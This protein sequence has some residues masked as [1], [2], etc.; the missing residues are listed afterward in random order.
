MD[1][2]L[3]S[4]IIDK[5]LANNIWICSQSQEGNILEHEIAQ[6]TPVHNYVPWLHFNGKHIK[7]IEYKLKYDMVRY[8]CSLGDR[9]SLPGCLNNIKAN[10]LPNVSG[11]CNNAMSN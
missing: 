9:Q 3:D 2:A 11:K 6:K 5:E 4:C 8:L 7:E 10:F 1:K